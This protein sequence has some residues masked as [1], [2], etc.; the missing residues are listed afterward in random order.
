M[1][2]PS[3]MHTLE[4]T[5]H[6]VAT[7]LTSTAMEVSL[8]WLTAVTP[9]LHVEYQMLLEFAAKGK[10]LQVSNWIQILPAV[11]RHYSF[12]VELWYVIRI[13]FS[14]RG[15]TWHT[16]AVYKCQ[17]VM[18]NTSRPIMQHWEHSFGWRKRQDRGE[19]GGVQQRC[20]GDCLWQIWGLGFLGCHCSVQAA[21][22]R[23]SKWGQSF[24]TYTL[25]HI[26]ISINAHCSM[27]SEKRSG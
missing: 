14:K 10:L 6:L 12:H 19:G 27:C 18:F 17:H 1:L 15:I 26:V 7:L 22:F 4:S 11:C 20:V 2:F 23:S 5:P 21:A 3:L 16:C 8:G 13:T 25:I 24:T 9:Q